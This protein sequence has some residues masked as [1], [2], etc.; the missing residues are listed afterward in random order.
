[1]AL[2]PTAVHIGE[3][4]W[5]DNPAQSGANSPR[6]VILK[7][8]NKAGGTEATGRAVEAVIASNTSPLVVG[9]CADQPISEERSRELIIETATHFAEPASPTI[10]VANVERSPGHRVG[11]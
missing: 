10:I 9:E 5:N 7:R 1:M 11:N 2:C 6:V 3:Q 4:L 8:A